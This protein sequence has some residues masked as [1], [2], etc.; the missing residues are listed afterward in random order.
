MDEFAIPA[1]IDI[2]HAYG[3]HHGRIN[4]DEYRAAVD[5]FDR[6]RIRDLGQV[7]EH[8]RAR[9]IKSGYRLP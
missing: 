4:S 7:A 6:W 5:R 8:E 2:R 1:T 3:L 9:M